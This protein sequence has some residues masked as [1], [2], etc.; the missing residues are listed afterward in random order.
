M[1]QPEDTVV[2]MVGTKKYEIAL[3]KKYNDIYYIRYQK[4]GVHHEK[5]SEAIKDYK[6]ASHLFDLKLN[7][8]ENL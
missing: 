3:L 4:T 8:L 5:L 1:K 2:K 7:D 6:V